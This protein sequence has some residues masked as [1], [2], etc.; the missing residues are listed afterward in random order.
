MLVR[1][2]KE[3]VAGYRPLRYLSSFRRSGHSAD[4][5][6]LRTDA[7]GKSAVIVA[8]LGWG[9]RKPQVGRWMVFEA[10]NP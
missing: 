9:L 4:E 3:V 1:Y 2:H 5:G 10:L 6:A 7:L 8:S